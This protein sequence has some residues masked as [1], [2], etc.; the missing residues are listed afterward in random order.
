MRALLHLFKAEIELHQSTINVPMQYLCVAAA[1]KE[2]GGR[3]KK[4]EEEGVKFEA[5]RLRDGIV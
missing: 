3:E 4:R 1:K 2:R 5:T